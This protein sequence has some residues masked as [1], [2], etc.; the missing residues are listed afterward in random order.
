LAD[1]PDHDRSTIA[2][3][4]V[5]DLAGNIAAWLAAP[6]GGEIASST[7]DRPAN[8]VASLERLPAAKRERL[9]AAE[10]EPGDP[11]NAD[12]RKAFNR[13]RTLADYDVLEAS[14]LLAYLRA[15]TGRLV[16]LHLHAIRAVAAALFRETTV[17]GATVAGLAAAFTMDPTRWRDNKAQCGPPGRRPS[18]HG[19]GPE[20]GGDA[21]VCRCSR[22]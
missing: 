19:A 21:S 20:A 18:S 17:D 7:D 6:V 4:I 12:E 13:A 16:R 14:L 11:D 10:A 1:L 8:A 22:R 5:V 9:L 3:G 15:R 2:D